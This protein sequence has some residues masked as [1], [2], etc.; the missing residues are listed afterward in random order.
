MPLL[1]ELS[2]IVLALAL[3]ALVTPAVIR[4]CLAQRALDRPGQ[5]KVHRRGVPRLGGVA[6]F[7][8]MSLGMIAAVYGVFGGLVDLNPVQGRLIPA[9]YIGLCGFFF[10]GFFD[11]LK[12]LPALPRLAAQ[13]ITAAAVVLLSGGSIRI[14]SAFGQWIFP[15]WLAVILTV[16]WIVGV[17]NTF[18]W[19]DGLDG[20]AAGIAGISALAFL[21]LATVKPNLPNAELTAALCALLVGAVL[22]FLPWNFFPAK[23][24]IGDGG[25]FSLGYLLAVISVVGL[26]KQ[27]ALVGFVAPVVILALPITDTTFAILRR[28]LKGRPITEPDD[29]HIH[30]RMLAL[31]SRRYRASLPHETHSRLEERLAEG[32]AHRNTVLALYAFAAFFAGVAVVLGIYA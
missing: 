27:A 11:D 9:I 6:I 23:T 28:A 18:N 14:A 30:H 15:E 5:R 20:L 29:K 24:F 3:S 7:V 8:A 17:V 13:F 16:L 31:L 21:I 2:L 1:G 25:A 12:S 22:G 19:I 4:L 32:R 26:F 10:I